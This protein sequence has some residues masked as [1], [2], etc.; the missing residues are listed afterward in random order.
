VSAGEDPPPRRRVVC[1]VA[2]PDDDTYGVAGSLALHAGPDLELTVVMTTSGEAGL[3]ADASLATRESLGRVREAEDRESWRALGL[4][5]EIHFLRHPDG[6][7]AGLGHE[8]LL[9]S[10][11]GILREARPDVV[12]T[13]GPDGV[14]GHADH[15]AVGAA[16]D[17]AFREARAEGL[18]VR[19]LL[20]IGIPQSALERFNRLLRERGLE[21]IDPTQEFQ[22][23]GVPDGAIGLIVDCSGVYD[24]KLEALRCHRTQAELEDVPFDLWRELLSEEAFVVAFPERPAGAPILRDLFEDLPRGAGG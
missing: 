17:A 2:H 10:Y 16:A 6:G 23:R 18:E 8:G 19:R 3:I 15:V 5:P 4:D 21:P 1:V 22:P 11:L 12:V 24:R 9:A 7:V 13:F 20:H 14:T